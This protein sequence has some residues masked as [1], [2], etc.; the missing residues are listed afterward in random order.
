[1]TVLSDMQIEFR[2]L[3][4]HGTRRRGRIT[5]HTLEGWN[6]W[7]GRAAMPD[8]ELGH[9]S[10]D[11]PVYGNARRVLVSGRFADRIS[12]DEA[13]MALES[14][15]VPS[16]PEAPPEDLR[17]TQ[18]GRTLTAGAR[19]LRFAPIVSRDNAWG[20]GVFD[21][22][23]EWVCPDPLRYGEATSVRTSFPFSPGG[24]RF[25]LYTNRQGA[26]TGVLTYGPRSTSGRITLENPGTA[27]MYT[28]LQVTG[29]VAGQGFDVVEVGTGRRLRFQDAVSSTSSLVIDSA[30]GNVLIDGDSDRGGR[31]TIRDWEVL[32][33]QPGESKEI[34][35]VPLGTRTDAELT[36]VMRP[37]W[38]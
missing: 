31:L 28:Q 35:F 13:F 19:L 20:A 3:T 17:V 24:L 33:V 25:P 37:G 8:R 1:M 5:F 14:S 11:G 21:W 9:G 30:T 27:T 10:F 18:F 16:D 32:W 36:A 2:G 7:S 4:L 22:A 6:G 34:E 15:L 23:A 12:R 38:W 26:R 29:P